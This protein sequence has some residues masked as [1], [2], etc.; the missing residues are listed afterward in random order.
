M[1]SKSYKIEIEVRYTIELNADDMSKEV[2]EN[3]EDC[4]WADEAIYKDD[5]NE[6][7]E[8]IENYSLYPKALEWVEQNIENAE[9]KNWRAIPQKFI[10][11]TEDNNTKQ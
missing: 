9:V 8:K 1:S 4:M 10:P 2:E 11:V 3:F 6:F 5:V 7:G